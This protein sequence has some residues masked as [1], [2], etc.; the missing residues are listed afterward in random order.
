MLALKSSRYN[1]RT[2]FQSNQLYKFLL[3]TQNDNSMK[4]PFRIRSLSCSVLQ[5]AKL[6]VLLMTSTLWKL[7]DDDFN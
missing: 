2:S 1:G 7:R 4:K 5:I 3:E 6:R